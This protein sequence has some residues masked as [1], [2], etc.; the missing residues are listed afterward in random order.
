METD[1]T[2]GMDHW[3]HLNSTDASGLSVRQSYQLPVQLPPCLPPVQGIQP[4]PGS[5]YAGVP[6][7]TWVIAGLSAAVVVSTFWVLWLAR[8]RRP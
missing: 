1:P 6:L 2:G 4:T 7:T 8:T 5:G 3:V